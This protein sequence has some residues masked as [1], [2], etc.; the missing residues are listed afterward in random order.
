MDIQ[1]ILSDNRTSQANIGLTKKEFD[2]LLV[3]FEEVYNNFKN[4]RKNINRKN[5]GRKG[6]LKTFEE[7][8]FFILYYLKTYP[9][10][11][12]LAANFNLHRSNAC[13]WVHFY[14]DI[15]I[16]A[17]DL[18]GAIPKRKFK[19][20]DEFVEAFPNLK[21]LITDGTERR[22]RRPI[23]SEEQKEFYSGKKKPIH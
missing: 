21:I 4:K 10:F 6:S 14:V 18:S 2:K 1:K 12:V 16:E 9:T 11:D 15:V 7:R 23:Y 3:Y 19:D 22:R 5:A 20:K 13:R 8:L 17:L